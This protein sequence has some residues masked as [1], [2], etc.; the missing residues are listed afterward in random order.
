MHKSRAMNILGTSF[1]RG[2][3]VYVYM[4]VQPFPLHRLLHASC[5]APWRTSIISG[6]DSFNLQ[7]PYR[8]TISALFSPSKHIPHSYGSTRLSINEYSAVGPNYVTAGVLHL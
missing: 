5:L 8:R 6:R 7:D 2:V 3:P 1:L 4:Y